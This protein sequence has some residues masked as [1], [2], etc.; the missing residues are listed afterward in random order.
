M[1]FYFAYGSNLKS[2]RLRS[3]VTGAD[4]RGAAHLDGYRWCCN[5]L[6]ADGSAKANIVAHPGRR[7]WGV[8]FELETADFLTLDRFEGGYARIEV[9]VAIPANGE[10]VRAQTYTSV[11]LIPDERPSAAYRALMIEGAREHRLPDSFLAQLEA[12]EVVEVAR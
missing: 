2:E 10:R 11:R 8:V 3:R 4:T 5:K 12:L 6:G 1:A 7:V 9:E